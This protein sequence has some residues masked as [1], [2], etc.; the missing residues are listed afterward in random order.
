MLL[1]LLER[2]MRLVCM[3]WVRVAAV[4]GV[5]CGSGHATCRVLPG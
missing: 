3:A 1:L 4:G 2:R 5:E